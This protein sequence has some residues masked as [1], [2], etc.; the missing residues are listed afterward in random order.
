MWGYAPTRTW[1]VAAVQQTQAPDVYH[2]ASI[3]NLEKMVSDRDSAIKTLKAD[4]LVTVT[5][6]GNRTGK[7]TQYTPL[8]GY[9][10]VQKPN[11]LRVI[12]L[13]PFLGSI[14]FD[15]VSDKDN[16]T[17]MYKDIHGSG[18]LW[19]QGSNSGPPSFS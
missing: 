1:S 14:G 9:I 10:F 7:E 18:D 11:H 17:L 6:G 4:V 5:T 15:M 12:L 3:E 16:F 2:S 8:K 13:V 19:R